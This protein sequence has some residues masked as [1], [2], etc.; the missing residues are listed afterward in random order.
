MPAPRKY[1]PFIESL[2]DAT[3]AVALKSLV[4]HVWASRG[5]AA[6]GGYH[7][8]TRLEREGVIEKAPLWPE[9]GGQSPIFLQRTG[10][11]VT[12]P[13]ARCQLSEMAM[14]R[15]RE[16]WKV[17][18]DSSG[19]VAFLHKQGERRAVVSDAYAAT[20]DELASAIDAAGA[21]GY[22]EIEVSVSDP[23]LRA[24][25]VKYA[26]SQGLKPSSVRF[27]DEYAHIL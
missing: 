15:G 11:R 20:E 2:L 22:T 27:F 19:D 24:G 26:Q 25:A 3:Q 16:G 10:E 8:V 21:A 14:Q 12:R 4:R 18:L 6:S 5:K 9:R 1:E 23:F 7:K 17:S 13:V